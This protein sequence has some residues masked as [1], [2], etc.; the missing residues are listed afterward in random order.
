MRIK[1]RGTSFIW[2]RKLHVSVLHHCAR[3]LGY[4][5][6]P[7]GFMFI[8]AFLLC[9]KTLCCSRDYSAVATDFKRFRLGNATTNTRNSDC[10]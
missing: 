2:R 3:H 1:T 10:H 6:V 9:W 5:K 7:P 8:G 4:K